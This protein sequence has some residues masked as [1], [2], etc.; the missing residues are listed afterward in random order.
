MS[1]PSVWTYVGGM[2]KHIHLQFPFEE[3]AIPQWIAEQP[4]GRFVPVE[5]H[6]PDDPRTHYRLLGRV[7]APVAAKGG[8]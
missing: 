5:R 2:N 6:T 7:D 1:T 8:G 4:D 3:R